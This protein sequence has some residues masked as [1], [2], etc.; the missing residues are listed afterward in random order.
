MFGYVSF[1]SV[2]LFV[3]LVWAIDRG[4]EYRKTLRQQ[5]AQ[6]L[7]AQRLLIDEAQRRRAAQRRMHVALLDARQDQ[8]EA[9]SLLI[10]E[11]QRRQ[12]AQRCM[13]AARQDHAA[14]EMLWC[15]LTETLWQ[16][17]D[18]ARAERDAAAPQEQPVDDPAQVN[19][20]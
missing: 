20:L 8:M 14:T 5:G 6:L 13:H 19:L 2:A 18:A 15:G 9:Q 16:A 12:A 3:A 17:L 7:E 1:I 4:N 11:T 10:D